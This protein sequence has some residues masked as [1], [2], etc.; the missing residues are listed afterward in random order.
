MQCILVIS[1]YHYLP[2]TSVLH[3][4]SLS[5][6]CLLF[7]YLLFLL[8]TPK[9]TQCCPSAQRCITTHRGMSHLLAPCPQHLW[10]PIPQQPLAASSSFKGGEGLR[11]LPYSCWNFECRSYAGTNSYWGLMCAITMSW[12]E[13]DISQ[14]FTPNWHNCFHPFF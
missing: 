2:P 12:L 6:S 7:I 5:T 4:I 14:L 8:I 11:P 10:F 3:S 13:I 9:S 1:I